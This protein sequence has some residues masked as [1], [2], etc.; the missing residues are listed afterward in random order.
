MKQAICS[1]FNELSRLAVFLYFIHQKIN[2]ALWFT[3]LH[4]CI[5]FLH[6]YVKLIRLSWNQTLWSM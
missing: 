2:D 4:S 5:H 1:P 3:I 6:S